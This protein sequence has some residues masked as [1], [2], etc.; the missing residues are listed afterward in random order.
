MRGNL[1]GLNTRLKRL[2]RKRE[3]R[4]G[5]AFAQKIG[6]WVDLV[7]EELSEEDFDLFTEW[8]FMGDRSRKIPPNVAAVVDKIEAIPGAVRLWNRIFADTPTL[9][10][11]TVSVER[12]EP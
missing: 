11:D 7:L 4:A 1:R 5:R 6:P 3:D 2:E 9:H 12:I 8:V 10:W